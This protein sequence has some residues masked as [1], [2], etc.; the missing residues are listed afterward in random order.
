MTDIIYNRTNTAKEF[1][2]ST[3][4]V[5][6]LKGPVGCGK[7]VACAIDEY[8]IACLQEPN[9]YGKRRTRIGVIR[10]TYPE[11]KT[12]TIKTWLEWFP[13]EHFGRIK[14]DSPITHH[15]KIGDLDMEVMFLALDSETDIKKLRSL[16]FTLIY[17]NEAQ[18]IP[19]IIFNVCRERINRFPPKKDG[20]P[21]TWAGILLDSNPP[22]TDHWLYKTFEEEKP[23]GFERFNY[24]A[25]LV[26]V[27][28]APTDGTLHASS[29]NGSIYVN[30]TE[31]DYVVVQNDPQYWLKLVTGNTD[32]YIRVNLLGE[33]GFVK[34]GKPVHPEY[35]DLLHFANKELK[36]DPNLEI[37]FGWDFG[38]TPAIAIVQM[39]PRGQLMVLDELCTD[40]MGLRSFTSDVVIPHLDKHYPWW[41]SKYVS[42]NDPSGSNRSQTDERS[43]EMILKE[44]GIDSRGASSNQE[45]PRRDA[46]KYFLGKMVDG[47]PAFIV[48]NKCKMIRK[49]L[50]GGFHY[51]RVKVVGDD[52]YHDKPVKNI[53]SHIMEALEYICM[54]YSAIN[55]KPPP[56]EIKPYR[57]MRGNPMGF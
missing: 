44:L 39:T 30:N 4:P 3:A 31:A 1:H 50:M 46:L 53:Y 52:R 45:T 25:A 29:L 35:N 57:I 47:Q 17:L 24:A 2:R 38:L 32:D 55:K 56:S 12:T 6:F 22:D 36:A 33:Y 16:E 23:E 34:H 43:C 51:A 19:K 20:V 15:I 40:D 10:N 48:S 42:D 13:E 7:S 9:S 27:D 49:G 41:R 37:G 14:W 21:I 54:R 28:K 26:K 5:K 18:Y 11:L 8:K